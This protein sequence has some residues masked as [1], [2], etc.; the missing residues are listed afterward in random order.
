MTAQTHLT[1][2]THKVQ[3]LKPKKTPSYLL[4]W[5]EMKP[6]LKRYLLLQVIRAITEHSHEYLSNDN[7]SN[8]INKNTAIKSQNR[9]G[10]VKEQ[11]KIYIKNLIYYG[12]IDDTYSRGL[13]LND[14]IFDE[15]E[16]VDRII[17]NSGMVDK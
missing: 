12:V 1:I 8:I 2:E 9:A 5:N 16:S 17:R 6:A 10:I 11:L 13:I 15:L 7:L 14:K 3:S 4:N